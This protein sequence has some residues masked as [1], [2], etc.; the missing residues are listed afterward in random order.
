MAPSD[1][2]VRPQAALEVVAADFAEDRIERVLRDA[3]RFRGE[4]R[5]QGEQRNFGIKPRAEEESGRKP[6]G[7]GGRRNDPMN[8]GPQIA[9]RRDLENLADVDDATAAARHAWQ[10]E[11]GES[12]TRVG[13][14]DLD[15]LVVELVVAKTLAEC[16]ARRGRGRG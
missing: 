5:G 16:L 14:V 4:M 6:I 2:G 3:A 11:H 15:L 8:I 13:D 12:R 9:V 10:V 1:V 7:S